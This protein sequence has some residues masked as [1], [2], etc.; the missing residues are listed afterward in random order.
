VRAR[1]QFL[2]P[3]PLVKG[4]SFLLFF[5]TYQIVLI[6]SHFHSS[7]GFNNV[8]RSKKSHFRIRTLNSSLSF[9][10]QPG[11]HFASLAPPNARPTF[12]GGNY[13]E[14]AIWSFDISTRELSRASFPFT[15]D[16]A[17]GVHLFVVLELNSRFDSLL[18][19]AQW[20]NPDG[21]RPNTVIAY[22]SRA[23]CFQSLS[24]LHRKMPC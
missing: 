10:L 14:S 20:I 4:G 18:H 2:D 24:F 15:S 5:L 11:Y 8:P 19:T 12:L 7:V 1:A 3:W 9:A 17:P 16:V 22:D 6:Y 13:Y 21:S 23:V